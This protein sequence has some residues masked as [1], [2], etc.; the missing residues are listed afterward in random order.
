MCAGSMFIVDVKKEEMH[1]IPAGY[2]VPDAGSRGKQVGSFDRGYRHLATGNRRPG[3]RIPLS[4]YP[5]IKSS[6]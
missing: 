5:I 6:H 3:N 2:Q 1:K 4:H